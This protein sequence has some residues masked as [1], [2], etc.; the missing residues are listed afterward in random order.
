MV[1]RFL[2]LRQ[3]R[4][5]TTAVLSL[6]HRR[7]I[8]LYS[9]GLTVLYLIIPNPV[10][11]QVGYGIIQA[12]TTFRTIYLLNSRMIKNVEPKKRVQASRLSRTGSVIF[13]LG[14]LVS[15]IIRTDQSLRLAQCVRYGTSITYFATKLPCSRRA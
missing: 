12:G 13:L 3:T 15:T 14:F 2:N 6:L 9:V 4:F 10:I 11:H 8:I 7:S 5:K 1:C